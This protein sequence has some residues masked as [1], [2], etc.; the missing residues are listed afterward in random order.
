MK[1]VLAWTFGV[2]LLLL[3]M[4]LPGIV[5]MSALT[6]AAIIIPDKEGGAK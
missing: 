3:L 2:V 5:V 4:V 6:I 1:D